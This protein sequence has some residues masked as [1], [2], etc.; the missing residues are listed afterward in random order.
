MAT[1][2]GKYRNNTKTGIK[3]DSS[4]LLWPYKQYSLS[5]VMLSVS[6]DYLLS[7]LQTAV[8]RWSSCIV[9]IIKTMNGL[10]TSG[11]FDKYV[12]FFKVQNWTKQIISF[13]A[14]QNH[15]PNGITTVVCQKNERIPFI[16]NYNNLSDS[17]QEESLEWQIPS[18]RTLVKISINSTCMSSHTITVFC[19]CT[20]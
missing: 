11:I 13:K 1:I 2:K 4:K 18:Y 17:G 16:W 5:N 9:L 14:C 3:L 20:N 8:Y 12:S 10:G 15:L 19:K 6:L 7:L